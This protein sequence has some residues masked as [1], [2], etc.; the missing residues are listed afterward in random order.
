M[1]L[2]YVNDLHKVMKNTFLII[3]TKDS[4]LFYTGNDV[5][6]MTVIQISLMPS[7]FEYTHDIIQTNQFL[8]KLS[9]SLAPLLIHIN[10]IDQM[11]YRDIIM[12]A[13]AFQITSISIVCSTVDSGADQR[14]YQ[15]SASLAFVQG[16]HRWPVN[17]PHKKASN[18]E[19]VSIRWRH[20]VDAM[21]CVYISS[22]VMLTPMCTMKSL[23]LIAKGIYKPFAVS[24]PKI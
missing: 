13:I 12:S 16:I 15:S 14:K 11:H 9:L 10:L 21:K 22:C 2:I 1:S 19:N 24:V 3:F 7:H 8:A 18:V 4:N 23:I 5:V 6:A 20:Y 17:S